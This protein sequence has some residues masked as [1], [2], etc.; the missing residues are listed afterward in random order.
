MFNLRRSYF[1]R[2]VV[3]EDKSQRYIYQFSSTEA[4]IN[5]SLYDCY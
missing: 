4:D 5:D 3:A 2:E 1:A